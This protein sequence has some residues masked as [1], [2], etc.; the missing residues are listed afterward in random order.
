MPGFLW[1]LPLEPVPI[2][3]C[4][5]C[6]FVLMNRRHGHD[7]TLSPVSLTS[8]SP[9]LGVVLGTPDMKTDVTD[10]GVLL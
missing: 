2:A 9:V 1:T 6:S 5:L 3:D 4:A 8:K 10:C 7:Y